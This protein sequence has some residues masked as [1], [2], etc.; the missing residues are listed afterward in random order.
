MYI[1]ELNSTLHQIQVYSVLIAGPCVV[2]LD[3]VDS[4]NTIK[5]VCIIKPPTLSLPISIAIHTHKI[6]QTCMLCSVMR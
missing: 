1:Q 6:S 2:D 5:G 3:I 4:N